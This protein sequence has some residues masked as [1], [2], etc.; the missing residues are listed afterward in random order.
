MTFLDIAKRILPY[1]FRQK[2]K[3]KLFH[4]ND[5]TARLENLRNAGFKCTGFIDGGAYQGEWTSQF[6]RVFPES[7]SLLVEPLP[8]KQQALELIAQSIKG[9]VA[10][11]AALGRT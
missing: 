9:S 6:W 1:D 5:M 11:T 7:P 4:V 2:L 10:I 8:G 3:R